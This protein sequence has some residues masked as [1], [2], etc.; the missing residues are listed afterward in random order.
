MLIGTLAATRKV[1]LNLKLM[2]D[3]SLVLTSSQV[4]NLSVIFDAQLTFDA[5][6]ENISE[7]A[8]YHLRNTA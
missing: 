4:R 7:T 1:D 5:H 2:V 3:N 8:F 6:I